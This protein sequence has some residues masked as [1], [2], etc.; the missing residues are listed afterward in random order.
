MTLDIRK[1]LPSGWES[2]RL[3]DICDFNPKKSE[4]RQL[5]KPDDEVSFVPMEDLGL[6]TKS[7]THLQER[8]LEEVL[9]SYTYFSEN[10]ILLAKITPCFENGKIGIAKNLRN[11][12]GFGSSEFMVLRPHEGISN[13][14]VFYFINQD[15]IRKDAAA[16]MTGAVGQKRISKTLCNC[17]AVQKSRI[18]KLQGT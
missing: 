18:K 11:K 12:V 15:N 14:Y 4:V 6:K 13:E 8:K 2:K 16:N 7:F 17:S 3:V 10:D 1:G 9:S 5:L